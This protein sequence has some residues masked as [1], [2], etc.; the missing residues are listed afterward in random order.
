MEYHPATKALNA[1]VDTDCGYC[2]KKFEMPPTRYRTR[3]AK[4][5][6]GK[7]FCSALCVGKHHAKTSEQKRDAKD[8]PLAAS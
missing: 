7:L 5:K 4:S 6:S 8:E 3:Y 2:G 1:W